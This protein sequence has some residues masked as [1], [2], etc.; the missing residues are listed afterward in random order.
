M[1]KRKIYLKTIIPIPSVP[2]RVPL[3]RTAGKVLFG[4]TDRQYTDRY[5]LF[6]SYPAKCLTPWILSWDLY[7]AGPWRLRLQK[8]RRSRL[9]G[10]ARGFRRLSTPGDNP[11]HPA[12]HGG[13]RHIPEHGKAVP[14]KAIRW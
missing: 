7:K 9:P 11:S 5:G 14:E 13:R 8:H 2:G 6:L 12:F 4:Q 10:S 1:A 3:L